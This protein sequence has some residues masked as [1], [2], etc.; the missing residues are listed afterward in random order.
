MRGVL[1]YFHD[2]RRSTVGAG[3]LDRMMALGTVTIRRLGG[4]RAGEKA[5]HRFL[6][7]PAVTFAEM[8]D[9]SRDRVVRT[10]SGRRI[11][12]IQDTSE[13]NFAGR[14]TPP[15]GLGP[16]AQ[17]DGPVGYFM[18]PLIAVDRDEGA[19]LGLLDVDIWTRDGIQ[20]PDHKERAVADKE[21]ARWIKGMAC[22]ATHLSAAAELVVVADRE[23]DIYELFAARC[24]AVQ[25]VIRASQDRRLASKASA[26]KAETLFASATD[27]PLL[28]R[29]TITVAG[30]SPTQPAREA[31]LSIRAGRV[32]IARPLNATNLDTPPFI[33]LTLV[34]AHEM[35][36][37]AKTTPIC[38]RLLTTLPAETLENAKDIIDI[39][40]Q[41]WRIEQLF[42]AL[43]SDGMDLENTQLNHADRIFKLAVIALIAAIRT[44]QLVDA[45]D[46]SKRP[47][48]DIIDEKIIPAAAAISKKLEGKTDRQKNNHKKGSLA[49]LAWIIAR[50]GGWN[51][52]YKPPGPKTMRTGWTI[53]AATAAGYAIAVGQ[54]TKV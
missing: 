16:T 41:R 46:G 52:Y 40:R 35:K 51:C 21:S 24:G 48:T 15:D 6:A 28:G 50:L 34:E 29:N 19:L 53:F 37:P 42:R 44:T 36:P 2:E 7:S 5:A 47:A 38:W 25:L 31:T 49:W 8:I 12:A 23:A 39:Y 26:T 14:S 1:G 32:K 3:L 30:R 45:R 22:A 27:L 33:E 4:T 54:N 10:A 17:A 11:L 43:K 13:F 20:K 9:V 18:H